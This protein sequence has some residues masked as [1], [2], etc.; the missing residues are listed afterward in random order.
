[1][2]GANSEFASEFGRQGITMPIKDIVR[3]PHVQIMHEGYRITGRICIAP[4]L[5][6][7]K[8]IPESFFL[9]LVI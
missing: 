3:F 7:L 8:A 1:M 5:S 2:G 4:I 6:S 9:A